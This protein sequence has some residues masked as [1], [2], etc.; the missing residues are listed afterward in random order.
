LSPT[1]RVSRP[2]WTAD[3]KSI[4]FQ[5][6]GD[7]YTA[8]ADDSREPLL[9]LRRDDPQLVRERKDRLTSIFPLDWSSKNVL[10]F[11]APAPR[12]NRDVWTLRGETATPFLDTP[13]DERAAMFSPDGRWIVYAAKEADREEQI[14]VQPYP[15]RGGREVISRGGGVEPIWSPTGREIF[16]RSMD[17]TQVMSVDV[18]TEPSFAA[19][20]PRVLFAAQF[21]DLGGS[22][23]SNYDVSPDGQSFLMLEADQTSTPRLN[24]VLDWANAIQ[25][26]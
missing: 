11:S 17:G 2:V 25:P 9:L 16:F 5:R 24:V 14:Y 23:W 4:T 18:R 10:V 7:L 20:T 13:R 12:T 3:G 6:E 15:E 26:R 21:A 8:P 19:G 1:G 22:Y